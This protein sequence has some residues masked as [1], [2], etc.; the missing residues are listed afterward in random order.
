MSSSLAGMLM[1]LAVVGVIAALMLA[2]LRNI[3]QGERWRESMLERM[4]GLRMGRALRQRGIDPRRHVHAESV[5]DLETQLR[6]CAHCERG[7]DCERALAE[8]RFAG[9]GGCPNEADLAR[10]AAR[11]G[12]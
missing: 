11:A 9:F 10:S 2:I 12:A 5:L 7:E 6:R 8:G 3:R 1:A 4:E